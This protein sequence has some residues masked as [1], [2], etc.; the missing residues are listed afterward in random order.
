MSEVGQFAVRLRWKS[1]IER[2]LRFDFMVSRLDEQPVGFR[3]YNLYFRLA[4]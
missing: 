2:L 4:T 3:S 1:V